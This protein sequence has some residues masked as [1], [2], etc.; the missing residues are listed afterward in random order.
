MK[1]AMPSSP[2]ARRDDDRAVLGQ[3]RPW[4]GGVD[5]GGYA[6]GG[7]EVGVAQIQAHLVHIGHL[8]AGLALD[9]RARGDAT[10]GRHAARHRRPR[11]A[12]RRDG[13]GLD[14]A[15]RHR[16][17]LTVRALQAGDDQRTAQQALGV[18]HGG[19][20]HVDARAGRGEGRQV[21]RDH[22]GGHI[23]GVGVGAADID[24]QPLGHAFQRLAGEGAVT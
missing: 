22:D 6:L 10:G 11:P 4:I 12:R 19:Y 13:P 7:G 14:R 20:R 16:I 18:A 21:G 8:E 15:L 9:Q 3:G 17:D 5:D 23:L 24:A 1:P 2:G